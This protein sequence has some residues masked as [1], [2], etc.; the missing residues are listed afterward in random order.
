MKK[1]TSCLLIFFKTNSRSLLKKSTYLPH[2]KEVL[3][4]KLKIVLLA[5]ILKKK[6]SEPPTSQNFKTHKTFV[7]Q[8]F[9]LHTYTPIPEVHTFFLLGDLK[10]KK[11]RHL[12]PHQHPNKKIISVP[13]TKLLIK[14]KR[15]K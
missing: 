5:V 7:V 9:L 13:T 15:I 1:I 12:H 14:Y 8:R 10:T 2:K 11:V 6:N 4:E 3:I